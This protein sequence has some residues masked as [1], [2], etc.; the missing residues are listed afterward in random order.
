M[1]SLF[2]GMHFDKVSY[3]VFAYCSVFPGR[4]LALTVVILFTGAQCNLEQTSA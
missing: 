4:D 3:D 2:K 1:H